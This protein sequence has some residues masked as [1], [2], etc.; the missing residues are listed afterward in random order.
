MGGISHRVAPY[1]DRC[2]TVVDCSGLWSE[3]PRHQACRILRTG[4]Y[5]S[6]HADVAEGSTLGAEEWCQ[7]AV[8]R[9]VYLHV[10]RQHVTVTV[11]GTAEGLVLVV[12]HHVALRVDVVCQPEHHTAEGIA[13]L[14]LL[15]QALPVLG[16]LNQIG[17]LF[18]SFTSP[19]L[20]PCALQHHQQ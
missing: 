13:G 19:G 2:L 8:A 3:H 10:E 4:V 14:H 9:L 1:F 15:F 17:L 7:P 5:L 20:C 18:G 6:A 11:E 16:V 12:A